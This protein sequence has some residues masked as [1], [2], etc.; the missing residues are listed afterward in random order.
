LSKEEASGVREVL[1]GLLDA[2]LSHTLSQAI[3]GFLLVVTSTGK[4]AYVAQAIEHFF[5]HTQVDLLGHSVYGII[6]PEDRL[7]MEEQLSSM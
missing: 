4:V 7:I 5:G 2:P 1:P 3:G 6:H